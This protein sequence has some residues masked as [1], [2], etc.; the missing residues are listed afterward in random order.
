ESAL[1][2]I[3]ADRAHLAAI[4]ALA[5]DKLSPEARV[6]RDL[7]VHNTRRSIFDAHDIR[8][9]ERRSTAMDVI[10]DGLFL[11]FAQDFAPLAERLDAI[12]GR[13]EAVPQFLVESR[14]RAAVPQVRAWQ[15]LEIEPAADLPGFFAEILAA[16]PALG[17]PER[18]RLEAA[19][20]TARAAI[21]EYGAWLK[22]SLVRGT[23]D[24]ALGRE[25]YDELVW[26]PAFGG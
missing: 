22:E 16:A 4:E 21:A 13:L 2:D 10:G 18:R 11:L 24:W 25:R 12:T 1:A 23:D 20:E 3:E 15:Q 17:D 19:A 14:T 6:E 5:D 9:W 7:E 8:T 26:L